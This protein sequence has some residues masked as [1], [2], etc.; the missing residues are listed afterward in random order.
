MDLELAGRRALVLGSTEGLGLAIAARFA[1]EGAHVVVTGRRAARV[2]QVAREMPG[3]AGV[4]GDLR[5]PEVPGRLVREAVSVMGGLDVLVVNTP[6]ARSGQLLEVGPQDEEDA[7][8]TLLRPV[9]AVARSAAPILRRSD[10]ARMVFLTARSA[11]ETTPDLALSGVFRSGVAA[12]AR[13]LAIELAPDVL[14]NVVVPGQFD[15]NALRS[16]EADI[17]E[18]TGSSA[19]DV[20]RAH[21]G[22]IPLGRLGEP[23]ELAD[24]VVFL[25]SARASFITGSV[26]RV[27]G[28]AVR[29]Y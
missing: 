6:G 21:V 26:F 1:E 18:R 14:V 9:L 19:A 4:S 22:R 29:G 11:L 8:A 27:D 20:R 25:A 7:Y 15:T 16:A 24:L 12:A 28:G 10:M 3:A 17:A 5:D 23:A 2:A 13:S